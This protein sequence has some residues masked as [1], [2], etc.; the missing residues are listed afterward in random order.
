M[1]PVGIPGDVLERDRVVRQGLLGDH[2]AHQDDEQL[3]RDVHGRFPEPRDLLGPILACQVRK[4][5]GG[6]PRVR[7]GGQQRE[8]LLDKALKA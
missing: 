8:V 5:V 6:L 1:I 2:V 7:D 3:V 4:E